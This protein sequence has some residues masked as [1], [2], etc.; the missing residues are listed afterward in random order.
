MMLYHACL[1]GWHRKQNSPFKL[2]NIKMF[3]LMLSWMLIT[4]LKKRKVVIH[5]VI[6]YIVRFGQRIKE[7][8]M[9]KFEKYPH[10]NFFA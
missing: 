3:A 9:I 6:C 7:N 1:S 8:V 2:I 4:W 10:R 5:H